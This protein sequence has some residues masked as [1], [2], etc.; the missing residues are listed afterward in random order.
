MRNRFISRFLNYPEIYL[1]DIKRY[2][3]ADKARCKIACSLEIGKRKVKEV[4]KEELA[5]KIL[6]S[7][8]YSRPRIMKNPFM[9]VYAYF[10]N[11]DFSEIGR[12]EKDIILNF[13]KNCKC[14]VLSCNQRDWGS[15][16]DEVIGEESAQIN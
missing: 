4:D 15:V 7:T 3:Q 1:P 5:N 6:V 8:D 2:K 12:K 10:N 16:L 14:V 13:L 9:Q 11:F